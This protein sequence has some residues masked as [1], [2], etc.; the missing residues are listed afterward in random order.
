MDANSQMHPQA[1]GRRRAVA[2]LLLICTGLSSF[3]LLPAGL[4]ALIAD[5]SLRDVMHATFTLFGIAS[6][7]ITLILRL[8][9]YVARGQLVCDAGPEPRRK[10]FTWL[11]VISL[12]A[13]VVAL[14][15]ARREAEIEPI[16]NR[17]GQLIAM[18]QPILN[19]MQNLLIHQRALLANNPPNIKGVQIVGQLIRLEQS[20][21]AAFGKLIAAE[22]AEEQRLTYRVLPELPEIEQSAGEFFNGLAALPSN[23]WH[24]LASKN[25]LQLYLSAFAISNGLIM[26]LNARGRRQ[27]RTNGLWQTGVLYRWKFIGA[28]RWENETTLIASIGKTQ[29]PIILSITAEDKPA[30][31]ELLAANLGAA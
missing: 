1:I 30:I 17:I 10:L 3:A 7:A 6:L 27:V 16:H 4:I 21:S 25:T 19:R 14:E 18:R 29:S 5:V 11:A 9:G 31:E 20:E 8:R 23:P 22:V 28:Y 13:G 26:L 15:A 12:V 24:A 2:I